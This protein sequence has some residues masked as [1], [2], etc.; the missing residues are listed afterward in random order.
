VKGGYRIHPQSIKYQLTETAHSAN[1]A[2]GRFAGIE[3]Y[4]AAGGVLLRDLFDDRAS[5]HMENPDL[6]ELLAI[7]KL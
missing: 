4:E 5:A 6:L 7:E 2:L 1:S 3:A